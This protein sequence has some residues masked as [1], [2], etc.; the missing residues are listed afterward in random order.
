MKILLDMNL[1]PEWVE[2]LE[3]GGHEAVHWGDVG[4]PNA[5]DI[6]IMEWARKH[7]YI[8]FTND[9][10][11]GRILALTHGDGPSILQIRGNLLLPDDSGDIV[12]NALDYC[13]NEM[14]NGALVTIDEISW[15]VKVL[16]INPIGRKMELER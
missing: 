15:R 8:V 13:Q 11:F 3:Q 6:E 5:Q 7:D 14:K 2:R 10:D 9:L 12:L 16:P 1:T 4:R